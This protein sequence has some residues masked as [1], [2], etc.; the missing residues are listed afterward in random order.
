MVN[1][2][3][4]REIDGTQYEMIIQD[5]PQPACFGECVFLEEPVYPIIDRM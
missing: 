1:M 4:T 2:E 3:L 5:E